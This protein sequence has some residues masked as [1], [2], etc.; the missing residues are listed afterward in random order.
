MRYFWLRG[1]SWATFHFCP[2]GKP[3][4]PRP[5]R[6]EAM[7]S[8]Q[9]SAGRHGRQRP[10]GGAE[11]AGGQ[12]RVQA[13]RVDD[14]AVGEHDLGLP[15]EERR[16]GE[17]PH[18]AVQVVGVVVA[19]EQEAVVQLPLAE[20]GLQ[21]LVDGLGPEVAVAE[22]HAVGGHQVD[23]DLALAVAD[24]AGLD[25]RHAQAAPLEVGVDLLDD[26]ERAV[27]APAG[28][29]A[30]V[31]EHPVAAAAGARQARRAQVAAGV[32]VMADRAVV[33]AR[34]DV[35]ARSRRGVQAACAA[36]GHELAVVHARLDSL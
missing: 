18:A 11:P 3:A 2:V 24:A 33:G 26:G 1:W 23:E 36:R 9:T 30:D 28:A 34:D 8:S 29:G 17:R 16:L 35:H 15:R 7:T 6:P 14:A 27:G 13:G 12:R 20:H 19:A 25:D 32:V 5:R 22:P 21:E 4:P 10:G 31:Q